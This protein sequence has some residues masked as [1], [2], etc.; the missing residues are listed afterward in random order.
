MLRQNGY[1]CIFYPDLFG[2]NYKDTKD[3]NEYEIFLDKV[4]ELETLL[5]VRKTN[6]YGFQRDYFDDSNCI[7]WTREGDEN[8]SGCAVLI[9]NADANSKHME[10]GKRYAGKTFVDILKKQEE[11]LVVSPEGWIECKV[12]AGSVSVWV[13]KEAMAM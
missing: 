6:A 9:S 1:P 3:E 11:E 2:A 13:D 7:G 5:H 12:M 10:I 8:N 4:E